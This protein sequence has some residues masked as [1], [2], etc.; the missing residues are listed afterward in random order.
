MI[1]GP[2]KQAADLRAVVGMIEG[3]FLQSV[4]DQ[5][6]AEAGVEKFMQGTVKVVLRDGLADDGNAFLRAFMQVACDLDGIGSDEFAIDRG[7]LGAEGHTCMVEA[8]MAE[9][10][11][12]A[13]TGFDDLANA[14][15][16]GIDLGHVHN[17]LV[18][19]GGIEAL[20]TKCNYL[21]LAGGIDQA[22][23]DALAVFGAVSA[24]AFEQSRTEVGGDDMDASLSHTPREDAVAAGDLQ[25]GFARLQVEQAFTGGMNEDALKVVAVAAHFAVPERGIL[26]PDAARLLVQ[27]R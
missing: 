10:E 7:F 20:H 27:I 4:H 24:G 9:R 12:E 22:V 18:A 15:H 17:A 26:V 23:F 5:A 6:G 1:V 21:L 14:V 19:D 3:R 13:A 2:A 11:N 8:G 25:Y 16:Q